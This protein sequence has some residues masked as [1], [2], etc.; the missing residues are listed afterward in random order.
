M[1]GNKIA[2]KVTG[3]IMAMG[4]AAIIIHTVPVY[5]WLIVLIVLILA[6]A[7][8]MLSGGGGRRR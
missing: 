7:F 4:G 3:I 2:Y 1:R 5:M 8:M 6:F